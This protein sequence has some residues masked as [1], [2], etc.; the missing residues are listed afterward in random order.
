M[1]C[2]A[3]EKR[4]AIAKIIQTHYWVNVSQNMTVGCTPRT[5]G[6]RSVDTHAERVYPYKRLVSQQGLSRLSHSLGSPRGPGLF[7]TSASSVRI[8]QPPQTTYFLLN[9]ITTISPAPTSRVQERSSN[10]SPSSPLS[11]SSRSVQ[12]ASPGPRPAGALIHSAVSS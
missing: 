11:S 3:T 8:R 1:V 6:N 2:N 12:S 10:V 9:V 4:N 5:R 7:A